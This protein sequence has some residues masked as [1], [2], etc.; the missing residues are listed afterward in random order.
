L[1]VYDNETKYSY[2]KNFRLTEIKRCEK[3]TPCSIEKFVWGKKDDKRDEDGFL[4]GKVFYGHDETKPMKAIKNS[5]DPK[6][7]IT[8]EITFGNIRGKDISSIALDS[9]NLPI[10]NGVDTYTK[11]YTYTSNNL[12][13]SETHS[14]ALR[15]EYTYYNDTDLPETKF[16]ID[17]SVIKQRTFFEYDSDNILIKEINDDGSSEDANNFTNITRRLIKKITPTNTKPYGLTEILEEYYLDLKTDAEVLIKKEKYEYS[18]ECKITKKLVFG[19]D[20][21]FK[22]TLEYTYDKKGNL[23]TEIDPLKQKTEYEY[24]DNNN[25]TKEIYFSK[26]GTIVKEISFEYDYSNRLI[27]KIISDK[28][29]KDG[30]TL[31]KNTSYSQEYAYDKKHNKTYVNRFF[32]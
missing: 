31:D 8:E 6:G 2:D 22:Y 1:D 20:N 13:K 17:N 14:D 27:K 21:K 5:Y 7:N 10:E 23:L 32:W 29:I 26:S 9:N 16:L 11:K 18:N 30:T 3:A 19:N 12:L 24:D 28:T 4:L 25:K 15:I